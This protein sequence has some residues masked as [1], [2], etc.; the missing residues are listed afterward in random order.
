MIETTIEVTG[1]SCGMCESHVND[2]IRARFPVRRVASS[3]AKGRTVIL[4]DAPLSETALRAAIL[5]A[6]YG[7]GAVSVRVKPRRSLLDRLLRR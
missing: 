3:R 6:G 5:S 4:S 7:A 1:M 2:A